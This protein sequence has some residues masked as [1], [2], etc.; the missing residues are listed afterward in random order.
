MPSIRLV[1]TTLPNAEIAGELARNLVDEGL[2]ACVNI[3][4][5][6]RSVYRWQGAVQEDGEVPLFIKTTAELYPAL[7]TYLR[8]RHPYALPE[9]LALAPAGGLPDYLAWV[10]S[11]TTIPAAPDPAATHD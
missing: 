5:P 3:L 1:L 10:A 11:S 2:A 4:S 8:K 9:I 7:E 6:C